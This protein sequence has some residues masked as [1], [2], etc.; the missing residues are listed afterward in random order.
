MKICIMYSV[1]ACIL[2]RVNSILA[3]K[4]SRSVHTVGYC[5]Q[6][7]VAPGANGIYCRSEP[8]VFTGYTEHVLGGGGGVSCT[9]KYERHRSGGH[10]GHRVKSNYSYKYTSYYRTNA[11]RGPKH[12][13][14]QMHL[15]MF[16]KVTLTG[17][18]NIVG[19]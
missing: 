9:S 13:Q 1:V 5:G 18:N 16:S 15:V 2:A 17:S 6:T 12:T 4:T 19:Q 11:F 7:S 14:K 8:N 10:I 3:P